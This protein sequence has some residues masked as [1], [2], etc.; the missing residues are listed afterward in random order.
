[1]TTSSQ[2]AG[3][4]DDNPPYHSFEEL[5]SDPT[6]AVVFSPA[7][8]RLFWLLDDVFPTALSVMKTPNSADNLEPYFEQSLGGTRSR[9]CP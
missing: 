7:A 1:M 4:L 9:S 2:P 8:K 6:T 5:R 3:P